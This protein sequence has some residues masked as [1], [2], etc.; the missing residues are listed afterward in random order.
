MSRSYVF[1]AHSV[2]CDLDASIV[3]LLSGIDYVF[4]DDSIAA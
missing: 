1:D 2:R 3:H 4:P